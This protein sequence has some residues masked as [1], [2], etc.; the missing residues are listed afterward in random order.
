MYNPCLL[1]VPTFSTVLCKQ[2]RNTWT[3]SSNENSFSHWM[4]LRDLL[5]FVLPILKSI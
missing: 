1:L 4:F 5:V 3:E 2:C